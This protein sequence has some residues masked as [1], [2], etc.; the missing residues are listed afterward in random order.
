MQMTASG[1]SGWLHG[2]EQ[3]GPLIDT[4]LDLVCSP[5]RAL[6][7]FKGPEADWQLICVGVG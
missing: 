6:V 4:Q 1:V 3:P 5:H 7:G 2:E